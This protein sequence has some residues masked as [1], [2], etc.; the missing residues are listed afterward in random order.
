MSN[1]VTKLTFAALLAGASLTAT[2][3]PGDGIRL[4]GSEG[5]LHP[6]LEL[7]GRWDS[8][9][10]VDPYPVTA[11]DAAD[12]IV[13]IR[14]GLKLSVPGD[15]TSVEL[16]AALDI[17]RYMGS[18]DP[19]TK[20]LSKVYASAELGVAVNKGGVVGLEVD[21]TF[22]RSDRPQ[23]LSIGS[24]VVSNYN[25]LGV[26][27]PFR[28]G[29]GALTLNV[30]GGWA[31]ETYEAIASA[32]C[33]G[34]PDPQCAIADL[35][36]NELRA[37]AGA[38]WK[39]LPRTSALLDFGYFKRMPDL[40]AAADPAGYRVTAGLTG[41]ITPHIGAT[42]KAG[43]GSTTSVTTSAGTL[44]ALGTWLATAELEWQ[45]SETTR[46]VVGYGHDV[47]VD[48]GAQYE[49]NKLNA[50]ARQLVAGR[51]ALALTAGFDQLSYTTGSNTITTG[52]S[53]ILRVSPTVGV[54]VTR[55][56]RAEVGY[57]YTDRAASSDA[58]GFAANEYSKS[59][60]WLKA[61][62]TY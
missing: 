34:S 49:T 16:S 9:A 43:Y 53:T 54:E 58:T 3:S 40:A 12:F 62:A 14:P 26:R 4:G 21:D 10:Y 24:S 56:L 15:M 19:V 48:P 30:N 45:P 23:A 51:F 6:F 37:G 20:D 57:A 31:L 41:L 2:A 46:V 50:E 29:G 17:A 60:A 13:H 22:R 5:R 39:F 7:E 44:D 55:W 18:D 11:K 36:Y 59:E 8:K 38:A 42:L 52:S 47:V 25:V 61:V 33:T 1:L 28:P 32:D 35:G 27:V